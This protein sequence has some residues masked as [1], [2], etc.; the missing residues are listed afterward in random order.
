VR[1]PGL[2]EGTLTRLAEI[3]VARR[4]WRTLRLIAERLER[5][6]RTTGSLA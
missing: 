6:T 3:F 2:D 4:D 1:L 5:Q